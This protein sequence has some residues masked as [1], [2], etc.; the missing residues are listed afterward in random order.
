MPIL[1][2]N[3]SGGWSAGFINFFHTSNYGIGWF[4][5]MHDDRD[6]YVIMLEK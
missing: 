3:N 6:F 2:N 4:D 5:K 1:F